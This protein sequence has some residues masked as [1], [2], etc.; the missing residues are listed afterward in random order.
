MCCITV[1]VSFQAPAAKG[2]MLSGC[3]LNGWVLPDKVLCVYSG[4]HITC[5]AA[6]TQHRLSFQTRLHLV[7][8]FGEADGQLSNSHSSFM[9]SSADNMTTLC[10]D[11]VPLHC[12]N[13]STSV[14]AIAALCYAAQTVRS[15]SCL[16]GT[17][18]AQL[19]CDSF[20]L[21]FAVTDF[22]SA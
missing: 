10:I 14:A 1:L 22:C 2:T 21:T 18:S 17:F 7:L 5:A 12:S 8:N 19:C 13:F 16:P 9:T 11:N 20:L 4:L 15:C 3:E 6:I